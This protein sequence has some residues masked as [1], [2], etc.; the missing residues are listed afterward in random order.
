MIGNDISNDTPRIIMVHIDC[1]LNSVDI[2]R[3]L[4]KPKT[5]KRL[6]LLQCNRLFRASMDIRPSLECFS[7]DGSDSGE[8]LQ[9]WEG[10]LDRLGLNPFRWFMPHSSVQ[11]AVASLPYRPS[12]VGVVDVPERGLMYGSFYLPFEQLVRN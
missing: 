5:Y 6:D 7:T 1:L 9:H 8:E 4:R 3:K 2:P 11:A 12:L 10:E